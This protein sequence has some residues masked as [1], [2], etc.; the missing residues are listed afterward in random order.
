MFGL[1]STS[2]TMVRAW[3]PMHGREPETENRALPSPVAQGPSLGLAGRI[4]VAL[5][6]AA[7]L[8]QAL[9]AAFTKS[10]TGDELAAHLP[11]GI[12]YW[13]T[14]VFAGGLDNP[15]LG[16]LLVAAGRILSG[17]ADQPL[18]QD[19]AALV[20]ARAP[21]IL[22]GMFFVLLVG[23]AAA[24]LAG[25][26]AG[27]FALLAAATCPDVVAHATLATL[28]LP[29]T[30]L[31]FLSCL[32][33]FR[34][35]QHPG[36]IRFI[37]AGVAMALAVLVKFTATYL[38]VALPLAALL[39]GGSWRVRVRTAAGLLLASTLALVGL[40]RLVYLGGISS[41]P[42][43]AIAS[44]AGEMGTAT[45]TMIRAAVHVAAWV[46]P[47]GFVEGLL[48][49]WSHGSFDVKPTYLLGQWR[50]EASPLYFPVALLVKTPLP[51][52][53]AAVLGGV[54]TL[55]P[56]P[57]RRPLFL[58]G[59]LPAG[60]VLLA[61]MFVHQTNIG[62]RHVLPVLSVLLLL[63]GIGACWLVR[64]GRLGC[65]LLGILVLWLVVGAVR[66]T[67]DQLAYFNELAGGPDGG[68]AVL[69]DTN[70]DWGQDEGALIRFAANRSVVINPRR[71]VQGLVA[72][73]VQACTT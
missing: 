68:D 39:F 29:V 23:V 67:P 71:P 28:D 57:W 40:S 69:I 16:Q 34:A 20:S 6:L 55:R 24:R 13:K 19:P 12:L 45:Q 26:V 31:F 43:R 25:P 49:K 64:S 41:D 72:A 8:A 32:L 37:A 61:M 27:W 7:F 65:A 52:L 18:R 44:H 14:G 62:V 51:V 46:L 35:C 17:T 73:N 38:F 1:G 48:G 63:S 70:L 5:V 10:A 22:L 30:C 53:F 47:S 59:V 50:L 58:F 60:M 33:A 4:L 11:S 21:V 42:W 66:I 2:C 15:Q 9:L 54:A 36:T 56:V 3:S